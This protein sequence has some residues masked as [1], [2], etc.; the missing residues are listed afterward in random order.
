MA[1]AVMLVTCLWQRKP[2]ETDVRWS[3][4]GREDGTKQKEENGIEK[5]RI[6]VTLEIPIDVFYYPCHTAI[7]CCIKLS[8]FKRHCTTPPRKVDDLNLDLIIP[9]CSPSQS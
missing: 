5:D 6:R 4:D 7:R 8:S 3:S 1:S 9:S 2:E